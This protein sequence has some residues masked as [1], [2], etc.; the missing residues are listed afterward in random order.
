MKNPFSFLSPKSLKTSSEVLQ[1]RFPLPTII[2]LITAALFFY[3]VNRDSPNIIV[4]R[5]ILSL[6]TTF[7]FSIG[8]TL[9]TEQKKNANNTLWQIVAVVYGLLF[10]FSIR[11]LTDDYILD[12]GTFF[13]LHLVG[14]ISLLFFAPYI[15]NLYTSGKDV[16]YTNYFTYT[17]WTL[18][19]SAIVG[20]SLVA[21]G[22]IA[23]SSVSELFNL[24]AFVNRNHL[25]ENWIMIALSLVAPLYALTHMPHSEDLSKKSYD[26]NRFFSFLIRYIA[27]PFIVIYFVIL[28]A[29]SVKVLMNFHEWPKGMVSWMVVGFSTFGYLTYIFSKTYEDESSTM[30]VFRKVFPY[31]VP[32]QILM[33]G[34]AIYLRIDQ[35]DLTM[36]RYFVVIF[37]VWLAVISVYYIISRKKALT[38]IPASLTVIAL[39]ISVGPWGVYQLPLTRQY[40]RLIKNL[41]TTGML[42]NGTITKKPANLSKDQENNIYS[43]IEY[44][45]QYDNCEKIETLFAK[46]LTGKEAEYE[47]KWRENSANEGETYPGMSSYEIVSEVT[48]EI[49]IIYHYGLAGDE[50]QVNKYI[51]FNLKESYDD[52]NIMPLDVA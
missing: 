44:V 8:V 39:I 51:S 12:S 43:G 1:S 41:E 25:Y 15:G 22:S 3:V 49:G 34:Y 6:I 36:N 30:Q 47:K 52:S 35:Y 4:T 27:T 31:L 28:Y 2:V 17:A 18:L 33:L 23:I 11:H 26:T 13:I 45:C 48:K 32:A 16:E 46:V 10:F 7:F 40:N 19:M 21:L 14:F 37:G 24:S 42:T 20:G 9:F 50:E 5:I 29:Y 38:M